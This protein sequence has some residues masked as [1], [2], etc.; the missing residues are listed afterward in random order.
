MTAC[1]LRA[2]CPLALSLAASAPGLKGGRERRGGLGEVRGAGYWIGGPPPF[3]RAV[4]SAS[5]L[6]AVRP[7]SLEAGGGNAPLSGVR[8]PSG[9]RGGRKQ[10][11]PARPETSPTAS[12]GLVQT[13]I[14][15]TSEERVRGDRVSTQTA[16][17]RRPDGYSCRGQCHPVLHPLHSRGPSGSP[18]IAAAPTCTHLRAQ[19]LLGAPGMTLFLYAS[20]EKKGGEDDCVRK[21]EPWKGERR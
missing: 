14:R 13:S 15:S 3:R 4:P 6:P 7:P 20:G 12:W 2:S 1:P 21:I 9:G 10:A 8:A 18:A 19:A 11:R 17:S 16:A 5:K